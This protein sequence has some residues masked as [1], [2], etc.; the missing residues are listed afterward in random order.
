LSWIFG[1]GHVHGALLGFGSVL[2]SADGNGAGLTRGPA[3]EAMDGFLGDEEGYA[4]FR[5]VFEGSLENEGIDE[6]WIGR[7]SRVSD[8]V[9]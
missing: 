5:F 2:G 4:A 8:E 3:D 9:V 6:L 7:E 1:V